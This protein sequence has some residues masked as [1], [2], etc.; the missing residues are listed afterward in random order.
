MN[1]SGQ[2]YIH[3]QVVGFTTKFSFFGNHKTGGWTGLL[4][5]TMIVI[6]GKN[7]FVDLHLDLEQF[8]QKV[9]QSINA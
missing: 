3:E 6:D 7:W 5:F 9:Y 1:V 2:E 4:T 8:L